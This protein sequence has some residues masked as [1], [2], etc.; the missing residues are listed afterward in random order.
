MKKLVGND[1]SFHIKFIIVNFA[2]KSIEDAQ[3]ELNASFDEGW[4]VSQIYEREMAVIYE[5]C[6]EIKN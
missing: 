5:L 6:L 3:I 4:E 1:R 2:E